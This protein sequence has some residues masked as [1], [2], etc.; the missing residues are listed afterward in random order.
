MDDEQAYLQPDFDPKSITVPRLRSIL[1]TH[2]VSY[3]SS[4]NKGQL[5]D[6]FNEHVK[7]QARKIRA[8]NARVRR[9]SRGIEDVGSQRGAP[10]EDDLQP[11]STATRSGRRTT[12]ARTEEAQEVAA[13]PRSTRHSTAPPE[14]LPRRATSKHARTAE[15]VEEEEPEPKRPASRKSRPTAATPIVKTEDADGDSPFST[16]NVFQTGSSPP[17]PQPQERRRTTQSAAKD[18]DRRRSRDVRR[19]TEEH[20]PARQQMD[21][22]VVP[23]RKTF[24]MPVSALKDEELEPSEEFTPEEQQELIHAQQA[25]ELVPAPRRTRTPASGAPQAILA[26][27]LAFLL[28]FAGLWSQEKFKVGYCGEGAPSTEIAGVQIPEWAGVLLPR[29]EAPPPHAE[30]YSKGFETTC[31]KGFVLTQHPLSF[32]GRLP[33][34]P[35]CEP[36]SATARKVKAVKER[37]VEQLRERNAEYECGDSA[38]PE[39]KETE[40]KETISSKRRKGMSDQEFEELWASAFDEIRE[41]E[42]VSQGADG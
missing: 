20:K 38:S 19:R 23:T 18:V 17:P 10:A 1:V 22:A 3:P 9:T 30:W 25:G 4:A 35:T 21:G 6:L 16:E 15:K 8:D 26:I 42:E 36:D 34:P 40:L 31:E 37:A 14:S 39:M 12:R 41:V 28:G 24:E 7:P 29:C 33:I 2:N 27:L 32:G 11:P 5:V 13:T